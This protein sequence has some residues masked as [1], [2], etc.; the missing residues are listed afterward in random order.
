MLQPPPMA[1]YPLAHEAVQ[2]M[3][4][5][6]CAVT[7]LITIPSQPANATVEAEAVKA[8]AACDVNVPAIEAEDVAVKGPVAVKVLALVKAEIVPPLTENL[9]SRAC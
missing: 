5:L 4:A 3:A 2:V 7:V 8:A 1:R 6:H 9:S